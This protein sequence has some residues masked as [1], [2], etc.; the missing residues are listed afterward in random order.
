MLAI[1]S[2]ALGGG[3]GERGWVINATVPMAYYRDDPDRHLS[4]IATALDL[5]GPGVGLMT[6]VDVA[7]HVDTHDGGVDAVSTVGLGAPAWAAAPD[8][9][10]RRATTN[11][12]ATPPGTINTVV[13]F[14]VRLSEA[15]LVNVA[16]TIAEAKAQALWSIGVEATGTASD[17]ICA[18]C[19]VDG[20]AE[21]YGG[22]RST[23][24][25]R[26]AR[27]VHEGIRRG[28]EAWKSGGTAWSER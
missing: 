20:P 5:S 16:T 8:G 13:T 3:L 15:A 28:G 12:S 14:P 26:A 25:A 18:L 21:P 19:P 4:D 10:L 17:A 24:G 9:H 11:A 27:A 7:E 23:W 2:G 22:P 1:A 6:G